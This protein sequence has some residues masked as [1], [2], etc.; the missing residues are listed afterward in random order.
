MEM[1]SVLVLCIFIASCSQ[2]GCDE[3]L[4]PIIS[5]RYIFPQSQNSITNINFG[6]ALITV[7]KF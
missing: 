2:Y 7:C 6:M 4:K 1:F 5:D 3:Q